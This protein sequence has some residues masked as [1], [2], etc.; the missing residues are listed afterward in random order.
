M[1]YKRVWS[2][3]GMMT[4]EKPKYSEKNLSQHHTVHNLYHNDQPGFKPGP[5]LSPDSS[6]N[7]VHVTQ[8]MERGHRQK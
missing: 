3:G 5:F 8:N 2:T 4:E 1:G 6:R 7:S